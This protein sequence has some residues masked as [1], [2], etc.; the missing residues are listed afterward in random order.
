MHRCY[1]RQCAVAINVYSLAGNQS[2]TLTSVA[3]NA[4]R[5]LHVSTKLAHL[6]SDLANLEGQLV[7]WRNAEA[8]QAN[9]TSLTM[10]LVFISA[11]NRQRPQHVKPTCGHL[12][13]G[14]TWLSMAREKAAVLPVPDCDWAIR[15]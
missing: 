7:C 3:P 5:Q 2:Q 11:E 1:N 6:F 15:F 14:L 12:F 10:L 13:S 9:P 8:L 4:V